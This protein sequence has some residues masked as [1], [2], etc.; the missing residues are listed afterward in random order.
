M[1][2]VISGAATKQPFNLASFMIFAERNLFTE[3][4][5]F[6][7]E[8]RLCTKGDGCGWNVLLHYRLFQERTKESPW[9]TV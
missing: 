4:V 7:T 5:M 2:D 1:E 8:V 6:L 3:A 9:T